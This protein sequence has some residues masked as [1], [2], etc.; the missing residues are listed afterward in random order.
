MTPK[1]QHGLLLSPLEEI[2]GEMAVHLVHLY[3]SFVG[4]THPILPI[5]DLTRRVRRLYSTLSKDSH[6]PV[7]VDDIS[8]DQVGRSE[9]NIIKMVFAIAVAM[10]GGD[11]KGIAARLFASIQHDVDNTIWAAKAELDDLHVLILVVRIAYPFHS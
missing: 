8:I 10:D 6:S 7:E 11:H 1:P 2:D 3:G 9:L 4:V 5:D